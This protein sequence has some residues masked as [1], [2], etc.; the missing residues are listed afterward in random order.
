MKADLHH[1][2]VN[3]V[4]ILM[5][6][7]ISEILIISTPRDLP[8]AVLVQDDGIFARSTLAALKNTSY[9]D[10]THAVRTPQEIE[11][12]EA[13]GARIITRHRHRSEGGGRA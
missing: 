5:L 6:A 7:G 13:L 11:R 8:T 2:P 3:R 4:P 1:I 9:F 10:I 12:L